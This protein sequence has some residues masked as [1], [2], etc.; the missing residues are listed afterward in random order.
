MQANII[1]SVL[2]VI[3]L[4]SAKNLMIAGLKDQA[5]NMPAGNPEEIAEKK[6]WTGYAAKA[7]AAGVWPVLV[8]GYI[9]IGIA[10]YFYTE[11]KQYD[12]M[13]DKYEEE[14]PDLKRK[15]KDDDAYVKVAGETLK[16]KDAEPKKKEAAE[17]TEKAK[18]EPHK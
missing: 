8:F 10:Y 5:G 16:G 3:Y 14:F 11:A 13:L 4:F 9:N 1:Q 7:E 6:T 12:D 15:A 17:K 2:V 18:K